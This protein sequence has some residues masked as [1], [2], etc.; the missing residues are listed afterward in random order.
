ME[1]HMPLRKRALI[2]VAA[3]VLL[4]VIG[5]ALAQSLFGLLLFP[6][7]MADDMLS[8]NIHG[9]GFGDFIDGAIICGMS[10]LFWFAV[11]FGLLSLRHVKS[12]NR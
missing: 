9:S 1:S 10:A 3:G 11:T 12:V 8:G 6:G 7:L 4:V 2:S 5:A